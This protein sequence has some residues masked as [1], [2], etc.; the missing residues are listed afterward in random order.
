MHVGVQQGAITKLRST[1]SVFRVALNNYCFY[2]VKYLYTPTTSTRC[3][4]ISNVNAFQEEKRLRFEIKMPLSE[5]IC[6]NKVE[7]SRMHLKRKILKI[8]I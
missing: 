1:A 8:Q 7:S 5:Y 6:Y 3:N 4:N 2:W